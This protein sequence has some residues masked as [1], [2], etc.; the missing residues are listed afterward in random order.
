MCVLFV[1]FRFVFIGMFRL[2]CM[3]MVWFL[4]LFLVRL[5]MDFFFVL[6]MMVVCVVV[7][8]V[9]GVES[10]WWGVVVGLK[11]VNVVSDCMVCG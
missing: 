1:M 8:C 9:W 10:C 5:L 4:R 11:L 7:G 3:N 2:Y 6:M